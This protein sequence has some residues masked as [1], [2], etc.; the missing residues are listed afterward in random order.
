VNLVGV[1][2]PTAVMRPVA[3][4]KMSSV[5]VEKRMVPPFLQV[6][7]IM[8]QCGLWRKEWGKNVS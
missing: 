8:G 3:M 7:T 5:A 4:N 6:R 2:D 1:L